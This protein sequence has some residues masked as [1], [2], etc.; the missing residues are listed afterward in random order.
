[1]AQYD[2]DLR[3]YWRILKKRKIV[4]IFMVCLVGLSSYGFAKLKE[5]LPI[6][7]SKASVKI[8]RSNNLQ[9]FM[10]YYYDDPE[11]IVTQAFIITS[12]PVLVQT[13]K[14]TGM[15]PN[16]ISDEEIRNTKSY[17]AIIQRL[18]GMVK[19]NQEQGTRIVNI[20]V[21]SNENQEAAFVANSVAKAYRQYNIQE[22]NRQTFETKAFIEEQ[23]E[24]TSNRL[25]Q[26]EE[27]LRVFKEGYA[28]VALDAQTLNTLNKLAEVENA[29]E[30]VKRQREK[31]GSWA[32][33]LDKA[34]GSSDDFKG[35][36]AIDTKSD[37]IRGLSAKL[38]D[39]ILKRK[40]L[41]FDYTDRHPQV[42]EANSQVQ[43]IL[44]EIKGE[45]SA[46]IADLETQESGLFQKMVRLRKENRE[47]PEKALQLER[48]QREMELQESLYS[49]LKAKYQEVSIQESGKIEEVHIVRPALVPSVPINIPSKAKIIFTGIVMGLIIGIAFTF[50]AETLDTSIG[51]IEDV[52]SLLGV[53]VQG[54]IPMLGENDRRRSYGRKDPGERRSLRYLITHYEPKSLMAEAFRSLRT[55]LQFLSKEAKGK[56]FLVTSS[57][58]QEGKTF[59]VVNIALSMAQTGEKVLL[60]ESDL[61]RPTLH[62][63]FG[64]NKEPGLT[65]YV[66][67][68]YKWKEVVNTISDLMLGDF[69]VED[70][71]KTQGLDN[72]HIITAGTNP[73]NPFEILRSSR[74]SEFLKE[75]YQE[76]DFLFFDAPPIM[77]VADATEIAPLLDGV[78]L[79]YKVGKIGRG[80]LKRAKMALDNINAKVLGVVLNNVRPEVGPEYFKYQTQYYYEPLRQAA[81]DFGVR[82][83]GS[84]RRFRRRRLLL[85]KHF[86][87]AVLILAVALLII[88]IFWKDL[89]K[90]F[91]QLTTFGG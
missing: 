78:L 3:D 86:P 20:S 79:V 9:G 25:R 35:V 45:L 49:Q 76:Y 48:L 47:I 90:D 24:L 53:P 18:K 5:P 39:L 80:V 4:I 10:G 84:V 64:L 85:A 91:V 56:S 52:E 19:A 68:N 70:I 74:F 26:A 2:V 23:L 38:S 1:M 8:E 42:V 61:R 66:L 54:L 58:V 77:P 82:V 31:I 15:L 27:D 65:D 14:I 43:S 60:V 6:F 41:L 63:T 30:E 88:G 7:E 34:M 89:V 33:L 81:E 46:R 21:T 72:L 73:L 50:V 57:F 55:N 62:T 32:A 16:E 17:L 12:F 59:N 75:A 11:N 44:D 87:R 83:K 71:L 51:T 36:L 69:E 37:R 13:A 40:T 67:G 22:R 29:Y 28:L